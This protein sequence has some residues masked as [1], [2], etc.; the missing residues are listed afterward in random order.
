VVV[1]LSL[2]GGFASVFSPS[3]TPQLCRKDPGGK[4]LY[5]IVFK[6]ARK[7]DASIPWACLRSRPVA[8]KTS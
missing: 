7:L 1:S 6:L 8:L 3:G 5:A 2:I 4:H